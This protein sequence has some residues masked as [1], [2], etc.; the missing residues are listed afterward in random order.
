[1]QSGG[2]LALDGTFC[3]KAGSVWCEAARLAPFFGS[4]VS[5]HPLFFAQ[6]AAY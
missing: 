1:M 4:F 5:G 6:F 2:I 3:R